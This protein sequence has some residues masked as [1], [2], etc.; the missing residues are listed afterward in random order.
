VKP[1]IFANTHSNLSIRGEVQGRNP[2]RIADE[3]STIMLVLKKTEGR[4]P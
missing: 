2:T 1:N 3:M 4:N